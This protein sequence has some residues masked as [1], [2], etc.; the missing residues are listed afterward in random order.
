MVFYAMHSWWNGGQANFWGRKDQLGIDY[1]VLL[2]VLCSFKKNIYIIRTVLYMYYIFIL[3]L[4]YLLHF[5]FQ[6]IDFYIIQ[7]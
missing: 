7:K 2:C 6:L 1:R 3:N 4:L 5:L